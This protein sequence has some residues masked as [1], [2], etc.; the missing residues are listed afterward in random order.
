MQRPAIICFPYW[1]GAFGGSHISSLTLIDELK[2]SYADRYRPMIVL[3][4]EGEFADYLRAKEIPY[5]LLPLDKYVGQSLGLGQI[6]IIWKN[7]WPIRDFIQK[8]RIDIV[9][10]NEDDVNYTWSVPTFLSRALHLWHM[11][12]LYK[13]SRLGVLMG[14]CSTLVS[15]SDFV[16]ESL[17]SACEGKTSVVVDPVS[18]SEDFPRETARAAMLKEL[19]VERETLLVCFVGNFLEGKRPGVFIDAA[20]RMVSMLPDRKLLF[21]MF[22]DDRENRCPDLLMHAES[23]GV[24]ARIRFM[25]FRH[26]IG[27]CLAACDLALAPAVN[28]GLGRLVIEPMLLGV[29]VVAARSGGIIEIVNDGETGFLVEPDDPS[30]F[31]EAAVR[32]LREDVLRQRLVVAAAT[33]IREKFSTNKHLSAMTS[34]Y[35]GLLER[36]A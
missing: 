23:L 34:V 3:H 27:K 20:A 35:E 22:G 15:V 14:L 12:A 36:K 30:A 4:Q 16:V 28:E 21:L 7:L 32:V 19:G 11:R 10:G 13:Q 9:H 25:G 24:A 18:F 2:A 8:H 5:H 1:G 29:P 17:P 26:D 31:A 6:P 33:E